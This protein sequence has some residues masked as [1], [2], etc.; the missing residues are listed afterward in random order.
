MKVD[1]FVAEIGST[2][3]VVN[4]LDGVESAAPVLVGQGQAPT[5]VHGENGVLDGLENAVENLRASLGAAEISCGKMFATS[6]AAGGLRMTV[7][8]LVY[9]MTLKAAREAA[10]GAGA[11]L[12]M[13]TAGVLADFDL[14]EIER[15]SPNLILLAGGTD[16]GDRETALANAKLLCGLGIRPPVIY[17]GNIQNQ[18]RIYE[19]L[20]AAGF[21]CHTAANVYPRLDELDI[22]PTR[23]A[24]H[25]VF[26]RNITNA[27]GMQ[28]VREMVSGSIMPTPGAVMECARLLYDGIGDLLVVDVGGSTTDVHSV[29]E[30][31]EEIAVMSISPEPMAKRTVEGDLGVYVNARNL[32]SQ[33]GE[34]ELARETGLDVN[35][36]LGRY[37]PI[38]GDPD[39]L[40]LAQALTRHAS[41]IALKRH[42]GHFRHTYGVSGRKTYAEGKDL[43]QVKW[44]VGTGGAL[45]RMEGH[46][47]I[48]AGLGGLNANGLLL[49]PKPG[50][51][52][53][54]VDSHYVMAT[55]GVL[56]PSHPN[57]AA[58]ILGKSLGIELAPP[59]DGQKSK[60]GEGGT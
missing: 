6:S 14:R 9:D 35:E 48:L 17:A 20:T 55:A 43:S 10:L 13:C 60:T 31:S 19:I 39:Q 33:V 7:H 1:F 38:P 47:K 5:T 15:I 3:T 11:N 18:S 54:L 36:V 56:A 23:K 49:L 28:R 24:I 37:L 50:A 53:T 58:A 30:G 16:F 21:Q 26:E 52:R 45:T 22:E 57:A 51:V 12:H 40:R 34:A 59:R 4:A 46:E 32:A 42:A 27:P 44:L 25:R 2:T 41:S 8:G 29:T